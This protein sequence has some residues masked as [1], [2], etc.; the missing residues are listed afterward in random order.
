MN[1]QDIFNF[2]AGTV[3]AVTGW[4]ARQL[5]D[6]VKSLQSDLSAL[7]EEIAKDYTRRDDFK[8]F[9][10]EIRQISDKLDKKADK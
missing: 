7:R 4:F 9:A 5:W 2:A 8:D 10:A 3:L 1:Y 6:A